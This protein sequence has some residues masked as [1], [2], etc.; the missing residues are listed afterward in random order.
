VVWR[1]R[2]DGLAATTS[3]NC[4]IARPPG[5]TLGMNATRRWQ[6]AGAL[7]LVVA[8]SG[9]LGATAVVEHRRLAR[10]RAAAAA[11]ARAIERAVR[12]VWS[13]E[14]RVA[15]V[16]E[17]VDAGRLEP[18][19]LADPWGRAYVFTASTRGFTVVSRGP[20]GRMGSADDIASR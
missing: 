2:P 17:L 19:A 8:S 10:L 16:A 20:D 11:Q 5:H 15:E 7:S 3:G 4:K 1:P 13:E 6:L 18:S 9:T 14:R 12:D